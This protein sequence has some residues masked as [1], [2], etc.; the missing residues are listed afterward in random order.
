M[1]H[2]VAQPPGAAPYARTPPPHGGETVEQIQP[3]LLIPTGRR[4]GQNPSLSSIYRALAEHEKTQT[5]IREQG[6][7][8]P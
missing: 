1:R 6:Q 2:L 7:L 4:K 8:R 5:Y 3:D